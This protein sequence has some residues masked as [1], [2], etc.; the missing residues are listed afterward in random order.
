MQNV[1]NDLKVGR[2]AKLLK[3]K[4]GEQI[5]VIDWMSTNVDWTYK[6]PFEVA[7]YY[8]AVLSNKRA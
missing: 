4:S 6:M 5:S 3:V 7:T 8:K 2:C 1:A